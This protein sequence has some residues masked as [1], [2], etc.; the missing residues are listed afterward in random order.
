M[1]RL[2]LAIACAV[3]VLTGGAGAQTNG[4][5]PEKRLVVTRDVDFYGADLR[6]LFDTTYGACET[7]CLTDPSC[8]AFTFNSRSNSCF[9]KSS[10]SQREF[11]EGAVSGEVVA[12]DAGILAG[13]GQRAAQL[14]F[15]NDSDLNNARGFAEGIGRRHNAGS[16]TEQ[17]LAAGAQQAA[18]EGKWLD[19]VSWIGPAVSMT[20]RATYWADYA[21]YTFRVKREKSSEQRDYRNRSLMA[22]INGFL[23]S[24][25]ATDQQR[26]LQAMAR[27]LEATG[28]GATMIPALRLAQQIAPSPAIDAALTDAIGKYGF[29]I[30][31]HRV[32]SNSA[33]PRI[34]AVFN[35][36]LDKTVDYSPYVQLPGVSF[37]A[38][39]S[40]N[41]ICIEGVD[42]GAR[43]QVTFRAGLPAKSGEGM[44]KDVA[45]NLYVRD[46]APS[47]RFP[48]RAYVLPK[49][50][51]AGLPIVTV[52]LN[53]VDLT[54]RRVSDRNLL[55]VIQDDYFGR[56]LA[57]YEEDY[58]SGTLSEELWS[59]TGEVGRD[60]NADVT[61]RLPMGEVIADLP[62]GIYAL[63][64][65]VRGADPYD[66]P[67]ATQWFVISDIG[68][69]TMSG[70]DGVHVTTRS[71]ATAAPKE[72]LKVT[73]LSRANRILGTT[74]TDARGY[75]VFEPGLALGRGGA[76]PALITVEEG[77][78]DMA[79]LS[80]TDPEFD[81]SDRGVEGREAAGPVDVFLATDRGAY[82]AGETIYATALAR[83]SRADALTGL[84]LTA[85]LM[86][87]DGVEYARQFSNTGSAG[88]HVFEMAVNGAAPRGTWTLNIHADPDAPPVTTRQVL[89]EDFLPERI[90]FD[91]SVPDGPMQTDGQTPLTVDVRY[92]FG[93]PG[94]NLKV[95]GEVVVR[96]ANGLEALPGYV[97]GRHDEPFE[98]RFDV[99]PV[100]TSDANG[101][102]VMGVPIQ[103]QTAADRP[104]EAAM[105]VRVAEGSGRP[106]ERRLTAPIAGAS[107]LIGIRP[108]FDGV[109]AE[110]AEAQFM[111]QAVN[112]EARPVPMRVKWTVNRVNRRYQWYSSFG[113]WNWEPITTR[114]RV[115]SGEIG[116]TGEPI[117]IGAPVEWGQ[118]EVV[119][120]RLDGDYVASS[121]DFY[122]GWYAPA[123]ATD[124]PDT[125]ELSLNKPRYAPGELAELRIV[126]RYAGK[127]V[128]SVMSNRLIDLVMVDVTEGENIL[129]IPVTDDWGAGAYVTAQVIR[130]MDAAAGRNP[131]RSLGVNYAFV[132][133]PDRVLDVSFDMFMEAQPRQ[134]LDVVLRVDGVAAG[135][136]AYATI[137]AVDQG[138]LNL[139]GFTPP[140]AT[141]HY[142][143]QRKLGMGLRDIYGRLIDGQNGASGAIRSGGDSGPNLKLQSP[144]PTEELVAYFSGPLT[145]DADGFVRTSFDL[146]AFNGTVKLMAVAWSDAAVGEAAADVIVRDP[147]VVTATVPRFMAPGDT[148]RML[149]EV[150]HADGPAGDMA[151]T[152][153]APGLMGTP[154]SV[155]FALAERGTE[156][157]EMPLTATRAGLYQVDLQITTPGGKLLSKVL[158]VPVQVNDPEVARTSRF[159]LA[160][161]DTFSLSRDVFSDLMPG[162]GTATLALGPLGQFDAPGLL[163]A[164]DR[165]PYGCTEQ[166]TSQAMP[167]LYFDQVASAMGLEERQNVRMRVEGSIDRIL[168]RQSTDGGF[169]LWRSFD[170]DFWLDAYVT[171]FLSRA[172]K[173]GYEVPRVAFANAMDNLRNRIN[174][175]PDF[176]PGG[177][178]IAYALMVL[179]R[180]GT[181]AMGDLRYYADVKG[182]DFATPLASAQLAAALAMYGDQTRADQM[183]ARAAAQMAPRMGEE[184]GHVWRTDYGT[185]LRDAAA[186]LTLAVEAGTNVVNREALIARVTSAG[187]RPRS[188]QESV[189]SL[190]AANALIDTTPEAGFTVNGVAASG[191]M[192]PVLH[193]DLN[194]A[195]MAI[196]NGSAREAILTLTTYGVPA[197]PEPRGG[198]GYAIDR[199]YYTMEGSVVDP[200]GVPVGTRM[201]TVLT[202]TPFG[203]SEARLMV[204]DPLPAGFEIDNP[205]LIRSGDV[206]TLPWLKPVGTRHS[207]FRQERFLAAVDW[208][209]DKPFQLAYIVR[210]ISPGSYHHPAASV[211]DMYRPQYRANTDPGRVSVVE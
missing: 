60:L 161:G 174:Y 188:T 85:V 146:P 6:N 83:D 154:Q 56:P 202:V 115:A 105:T 77:D 130:P 84:P 80:L 179:A 143:G 82:R 97:F 29:R 42:H 53:E 119:V 140:D 35:E 163:A 21:E 190:L 148:S 68:L 200:T 31:E 198:N 45:L 199:T 184:S 156:R 75:A 36:P 121:T 26:S 90:D 5:V 117:R 44:V 11:Y 46:R 182:G 129:N 116:L 102:A 205:N 23:R 55:R 170:G 167:L 124:S 59:G 128:V 131:A 51:D 106:V 2:A 113:N 17:D 14:G 118:Y 162:T 193:D 192:V 157:F 47:V 69:A 1:T 112:A 67:G 141:G 8:K 139:T 48:G 86:R 24:A 32:D 135:E 181:A 30:S 7:A 103:A 134:P 172:K 98:T 99:L 50:T 152:A 197:V 65:K 76:A 153:T 208:R 18:S 62:A 40:D 100:A 173:Q 155:N 107:D 168:S 49:T 89:V 203:K 58:F 210:A 37:S 122:A 132:N 127:A 9:P 125:L 187:T 61:T 95:E 19:A 33:S 183:F 93:A 196:A 206:K 186:V 114:T 10:I 43:Y 159:T 104:L 73:L 169:G 191:P 165:Y 150:I 16:W 4:P 79:F 25:S 52:N 177:E 109:A 22:S 64:A 209:S 147:V 110:G 88:G 92:L 28:R 12:T 194:A 189:W 57:A 136:T 15:L 142:F 158:N 149:L 123:D 120:E 164:L 3:G 207:E 180:E 63:Q 96:P 175:A 81:L 87:P 178:D 41:E 78:A 126:P 138:I 54:L 72:G 74:T 94:A 211:E 145:V 144:P 39:A 201:V 66:T 108:L 171:D 160:A 34:C 20:D 151:I 204:N 27:A 185:N 133:T 38:E 111:I 13:A 70:A 71:L 176:E 91:L 101:R 195:P 166:T 137:A